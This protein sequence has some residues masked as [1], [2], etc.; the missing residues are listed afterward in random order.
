MRI[1][2]VDASIDPL[3]GGQSERTLQMSRWLA[4]SGNSVDVLVLNKGLSRDR[5][6]A[7]HPA[8]VIPL[9]TL[10]R[11]FYVPA[12]ASVRDVVAA[13]DVIHLMGYWSVMNAIVFKEARRAG[14]PYVFCPAGSWNIRGRSKM[15]KLGYDRLVGSRIVSGAAKLIA[16]TRQECDVFESYGV[17]PEKIVVMPNAVDPAGFAVRDDEAFRTKFALSTRPF[18]L[19]VGR[20]APVKGPD[21]LLDA[22]AASKSKASHD[23]LFAGPDEGM[24]AGLRTRAAELGVADRV[25]LIGSI[26]GADKSMAYHAAAVLAIPSRHEAMSI[27]VLEAGVCGTPV[28]LTDQCGL[29]EVESAGGGLV[30]HGSAAS[31]ADGLDRILAADRA[32]MSERIRKFVL[33]RYTWQAAVPQ[34][35]K[36]YDEIIRCAS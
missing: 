20:L 26:G 7:I 32:G 18:I 5:I 11:R 17:A 12:D 34:Y 27:V 22:Y 33:D 36:L 30:V 6:D 14:T 19:F 23:L 9:K 8:N 15:L 35:M 24:A 1:L 28:L 3:D 25:H 21:L 13:A 29:D 2:N 16:I 10:S 31:I 4:L